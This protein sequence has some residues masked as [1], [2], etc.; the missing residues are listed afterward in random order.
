MPISGD[1][2]LCIF[3]RWA[4]GTPS[5]SEDTMNFAALFG[6]TSVNE[7]FPASKVSAFYC[8]RLLIMGFRKAS[9]DAVDR[10]CCAMIIGSETTSDN[11][12]MR[13][14]QTKGAVGETEARRD[15]SCGQ[16]P[17]IASFLSRY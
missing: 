13:R 4:S 15:P 8:R 2:N 16:Q 14:V 17:Q 11:A 1:F 9:E 10:S 5:D 12:D 7:V 3:D 6:I